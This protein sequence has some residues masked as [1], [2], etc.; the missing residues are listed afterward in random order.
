MR[1][2]RSRTTPFTLTKADLRLN[3]LELEQLRVACLQVRDHAGVDQ[4]AID[5]VIDVVEAILQSCEELLEYD[6]TLVNGDPAHH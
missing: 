4:P 6:W 1:S 5:G 3:C 2:K